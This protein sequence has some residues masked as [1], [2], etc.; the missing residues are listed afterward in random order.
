M[1]MT[2]T[3][4][5]LLLLLPLA[6]ARAQTPGVDEVPEVR[7]Y[8]V[9]MIIFT[10]AQDVGPG[11]EVFVGDKIV[12]EEIPGDIGFPPP[13]AVEDTLEDPAPEVRQTE[14]VLLDEDDFTMGD[15]MERLRRLD[16]YQP[17][18]HFGWTQATW[19]DEETNA[20]ALASLATPPP[21]LDGSLKLYLSRFLHLVVDLALD[22]PAAS[23]RESS[24]DNS[25]PSYG[26][27]RS[28]VDFG[29]AE[30]R[31]GPVRYRIQEDRIFRSGELRYFD[32][33]KFGVLARVTRVEASEE[34]APSEGAELLGYPLD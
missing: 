25:Y 12:L 20:M 29:R 32:H 26:D 5:I 2:M 6:A 13:A 21:G 3:R 11:T 28:T 23:P 1:R 27:L 18:M 33:P 8:T 14:F 16:V 34:Q 17:V 24:Q 4:I 10:Y 22:A 31:V 19:P 9:E 30:T 7:R 15:I